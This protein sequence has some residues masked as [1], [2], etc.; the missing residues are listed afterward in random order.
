MVYHQD[1]ITQETWSAWY[2]P[3]YIIDR[4][5][6]KEKM[7]D[8]VKEKDPEQIDE[9]IVNRKKIAAYEPLALF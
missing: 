7:K 8:I 4:W 5:A 2:T 3:I 6:Y 1:T 9:P